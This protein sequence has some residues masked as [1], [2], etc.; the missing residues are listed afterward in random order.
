M[1]TVR[2]AKTTWR[3]EHRCLPQSLQSTALATYYEV[4][5]PAAETNVR[6][7]FVI[8]GGNHLLPSDSSN[9]R[10]YCTC[11]VF[12]TC[13]CALRRQHSQKKA[14]RLEPRWLPRSLKTLRWPRI[15][16][17]GL[18]QQTPICAYNFFLFYTEIVSCHQ[19]P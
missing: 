13:R 3:P 2:C 12:C 7:E 1:L 18:S 15:I 6:D 4:P 10:K 19:N 11:H 17:F 5:A 9:P 14:A 8:F 16:R